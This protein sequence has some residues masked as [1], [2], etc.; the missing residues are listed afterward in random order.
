MPSLPSRSWH[1]NQETLEKQEAWACKAVAE[2][3]QLYMSLRGAEERLIGVDAAV[4]EA[5]AAPMPQSLLRSFP[6]LQ[7][8]LRMCRMQICD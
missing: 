8:A 6:L 3:Q 7:P 2:Q 1:G 5:L 4:A